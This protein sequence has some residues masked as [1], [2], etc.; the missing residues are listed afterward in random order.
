[1][2]K[3]NIEDDTNLEPKSEIVANDNDIHIVNA[4]T[5]LTV[6]GALDRHRNEKPQITHFNVVCP[7]HTNF[8]MESIEYTFKGNRDL[9][10]KSLEHTF[11]GNPDLERK[12]RHR[13]RDLERKLR[14]RN[15]LLP[16]HNR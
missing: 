10:R 14:H 3:V 1:M 2:Y 15:F 5:E 9:E 13:N 7:R 11:K 16:K 4:L 12:I 8:A 6:C